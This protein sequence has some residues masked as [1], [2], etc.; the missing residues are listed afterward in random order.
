[1]LLRATETV[2]RAVKTVNQCLERVLRKVETALRAR[3]TRLRPNPLSTMTAYVDGLLLTATKN[4]E[5][6]DRIRAYDA[7][8]GITVKFRLVISSFELPPVTLV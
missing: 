1:M 5:T 8:S 3:E 2:L 6:K 7:G 4:N